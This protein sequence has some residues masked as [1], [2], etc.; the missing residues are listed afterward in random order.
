MALKPSKE[1]IK[2]NEKI[3]ILIK[4]TYYKITKFRQINKYIITVKIWH[5]KFAFLTLR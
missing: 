4:F 1:D 3:V 2:S 5:Q